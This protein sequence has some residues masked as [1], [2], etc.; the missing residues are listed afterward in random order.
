MELEDDMFIVDE[1]IDQRIRNGK[2]QYFVKWQGYPDPEDNTWEPAENLSSCPTVVEA[3]ETKLKEKE[4]KRRKQT[5]MS[6]V[7]SAPASKSVVTSTP[8]R[9]ANA[10]LA[11][12][13]EL[14]KSELDG[15]KK[16]TKPPEHKDRIRKDSSSKKDR[17]EMNNNEPKVAEK[18]FLLYCANVCISFSRNLELE[19]CL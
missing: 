5:N 7:S 13:V 15:K 4:D 3:F 16:S 12:A 10:K 1:I 19:K 9:P 17:T 18:R 11:K 2:L 6:T 8:I 14:E